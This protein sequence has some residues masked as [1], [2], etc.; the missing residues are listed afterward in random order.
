[1]LQDEIVIMTEKEFSYI[2]NIL[3]YKYG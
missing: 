3:L 1:V 2:L